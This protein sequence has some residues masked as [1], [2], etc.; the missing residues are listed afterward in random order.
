VFR[1]VC[2]AAV[3][4][5]GPRAARFLASRPAAAALAAGLLLAAVARADDEDDLLRVFITPADAT[6]AAGAT[7][8]VPE[9]LFRALARAGAEPAAVRIVACDVAAGMPGDGDGGDVAPWTVTVDVDADAGTTLV[10]DQG[11]SGGRISGTQVRI[12]GATVP[13][14]VEAAGRTARIPLASAGRQRLEWTVEPAT[15][16]R[17]DVEEFVVAVPCAAA[18]RL[19]LTGGADA[20]TVACEAAPPQGRFHTVAAVG[21]AAGDAPAFDIAGA[22]LVRACRVVDPRLRLA[23]AVR[24]VVSRND[25][26]WDLDACR[27]VATFAIESPNEVVR[28]F[29]VG[30]DPGLVLAE[31]IEGVRAVGPQRFVVERLEPLRGGF[32]VQIPFRMPLA[33][34]TGVFAVPG[35]W[36]EDAAVDSRTTQLVPAPD[37]SVEVTLPDGVTAAPRDAESALQGFAWRSDIMRPLGRTAAAG[38][39]TLAAALDAAARRPLVTVERRRGEL[40]AAQQLAVEFDGDQIQLTLQARIDATSAA[41]VDVAVDVPEACVIDRVELMEDRTLAATAA[42]RGPADIRWSRV[43]PGSLLVVAQRPRSGRYRLEVAARLPGRPPSRGTLPVMRAVLPGAAPLVASWRTQDGRGAALR[44]TYGE[45]IDDAAALP[46]LERATSGFLDLPGGE[47]GIIFELGD[48]EAPPAAAVPPAAAGTGQVSVG[49]DPRQAR[50]ELAD[51][52]LEMD[53]RG[54]AWGRVQFDVVAAGE[55]LQLALPAGMRLFE[56][57]VDGRAAAAAPQD[58]GTWL[59]PLFDVRWPRSVLAVFAGDVGTPA[60]D[61]APFAIAA[62]RL[63]AVPCR[64]LAWTVRVAPGMVLRVAEPARPVDAQEMAAQRQAVAERLEDEFIRA[65]EEAAP[66]ERSRMTDFARLRRAGAALPAE[67]AWSRAMHARADDVVRVVVDEPMDGPLVRGLVVRLGRAT[68]PTTGM[69][70]I[71]TLLILAVAAAVWHTV[72]HWNDAWRESAARVVPGVAA[73]AGVVWL[74]AFEP[75]WPG[76]LSLVTGGLLAFARRRRGGADVR[77]GDSTIT[78]FA[79]S[80]TASSAAAPSTET[81]IVNRR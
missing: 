33:D 61:G 19:T 28:S 58:D 2:W 77:T 74:A 69:R 24:S 79:P 11:E 76:W 57:L 73:V 5:G 25:V 1:A 67:E 30:V 66:D 80:A 29:T 20:G 32:S 47:T 13:M 78:Q 55:T 38:S 56:V 37:L 21:G 70:A 60:V 49:G 52:F 8:L 44:P 62:P 51:V 22:A 40:R 46:P 59:V 18:G 63:V 34:P 17:G 12:D 71:A 4:A 72:G 7:A 10:V 65:I 53:G 35:A 15:L 48:I 31:E 43:G 50:V 26:F 45:P 9:P 14:R 27:L 6:A 54:R 23:A 64:T 16:R 3:A 81:F 41:L 68:D 42:D 39:A 75:S 36:V